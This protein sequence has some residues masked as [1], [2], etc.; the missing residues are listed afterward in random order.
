MNGVTLLNDQLS[1]QTQ[2]LIQNKKN[3]NLALRKGDAT[4]SGEFSEKF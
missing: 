2:L 3:I 4:K 1:L